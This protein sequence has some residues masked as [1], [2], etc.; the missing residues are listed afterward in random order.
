MRNWNINYYIEKH[1]YLHLGFVLFHR[2]LIIFFSI[3]GLAKDRKYVPPISDWDNLL[4]NGILGNRENRM[5]FHHFQ[6]L[7]LGF[8]IY[9]YL[10][11]TW[12]YICCIVC[13]SP[14]SN[15]L[16]SFLYFSFKFQI[17]KDFVCIMTLKYIPTSYTVDTQ[18]F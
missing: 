6:C 5:L 7:D 18:N 14:P 2:L 1:V 10:V 9:S 8:S 17:L 12:M 3:C 11:L 16:T 4:L 15:G 13:T